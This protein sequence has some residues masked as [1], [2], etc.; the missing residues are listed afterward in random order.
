MKHVTNLLIHLII[1]LGLISCGTPDDFGSEQVISGLSLKEDGTPFS[2]NAKIIGISNHGVAAIGT[3]D[4]DGN[5]K[6]EFP[7]NL[8]RAGKKSKTY[9]STIGNCFIKISEGENTLFL[10]IPEYQKIININAVTVAASQLLFST[11]NVDLPAIFDAVEIELAASNKEYVLIE[12]ESTLSSLAIIPQIG[13]DDLSKSTKLVLGSMFGFDSS[14]EVAVKVDNFLTGSIKSKEN[15]MLKA[16]ASLTNNLISAIVSATNNPENISYLLN[17]QSFYEALGKEIAN[18]E[19]NLGATEFTELLVKTIQSEEVQMNLS[20]IAADLDAYVLAVNEDDATPFVVEIPVISMSPSTATLSISRNIDEIS[21][22]AENVLLSDQT[23]LTI[24]V[25]SSTEE[26]IA[27]Q[28]PVKFNGEIFELDAN[29]IVAT[30]YYG[31]EIKIENSAA[32]ENGKINLEAIFAE[33]KVALEEQEYPDYYLDYVPNTTNNLILTIS[34]TSI[35]RTDITNVPTYLETTTEIIS[36]L[37]GVRF[38]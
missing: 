13:E 1:L 24:R 26:M 22:S 30:F 28:I 32:M 5:Y 23:T 7:R 38:E 16:T 37:A 21:I 4:S 6:I 8:A 17:N 34:S 20:L 11:L 18:S 35:S 10:V 3:V 9:S 14:G 15:Y 12:N 36:S 29:P 2:V 25:F 19:E 33:T 31:T 27:L